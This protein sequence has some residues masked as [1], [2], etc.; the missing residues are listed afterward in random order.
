[1]AILCRPQFGDITTLTQTV[2][3]RETLLPIW[4]GYGTF[5][6]DMQVTLY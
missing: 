2:P 4:N 1:M 3:Q 6:N 5:K